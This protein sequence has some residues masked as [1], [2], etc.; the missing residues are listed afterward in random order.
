LIFNIESLILNGYFNAFWGTL[1]FKVKEQ[2]DDAK[3]ERLFFYYHHFIEFESL[4]T[5]PE[6]KKWCE[7][8]KFPGREGEGDI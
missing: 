4:R 8:A 1:T 3:I 6:G 5:G 2:Y 7:L